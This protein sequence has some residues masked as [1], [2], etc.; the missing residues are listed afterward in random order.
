MH[1]CQYSQGQSQ[2]R[3]LVSVSA[4]VSM[5]GRTPPPPRYPQSQ[6]PPPLR[7]PQSLPPTPPPPFASSER[8][9]AG[10]A[11]S[12]QPLGWALHLSRKS[13]VNLP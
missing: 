10:L 6:A 12:V 9:V 1:Q 8:G 3:Q 7:Y 11:L 13:P 5:A 2:S 4:S